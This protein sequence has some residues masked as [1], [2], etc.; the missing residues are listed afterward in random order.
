MMP[1]ALAGIGAIA[2]TQP[3]DAACPSPR[4]MP[5]IFFQG[6]ADKL[7]P[8]NGGA[9]APQ[10]GNRGT[11]LS[12]AQTLEIWRKRNGCGAETRTQLPDTDPLPVTVVTFACPA[13]RGLEDV[14]VQGGG[15]SWPGAHQG[16]LANMIL[17]PVSDSISANEMM[18]TFFQKQAPRLDPH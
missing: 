10:F 9:I 1:E 4:P 7:V 13:G 17:G 15:H 2:A 11:A 18:W 3:V 6:T 5:A 14:I 16:I 12:N 8:F